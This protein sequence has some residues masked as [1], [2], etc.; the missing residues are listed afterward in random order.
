M[1]ELLKSIFSLQPK[2]KVSEYKI[3]LNM[4]T[5]GV[6]RVDIKSLREYLATDE[7]KLKNGIN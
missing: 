1:I 3:K 2:P 7:G 5:P 6:V 4:I